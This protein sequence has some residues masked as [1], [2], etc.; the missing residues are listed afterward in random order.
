MYLIVGVDP[1]KTIGIACLDL[2]GRLVF[3]CHHPNE[4]LEH[5]VNSI[6]G[7]GTPIIVA[8][9]KSNPSEL[10]RKLNA[11]FGARLFS[12]KREFSSELKRRL[13]RTVALANQHECDAYSAA[14]AAYNHYSNKFHQI[15]HMSGKGEA[16]L[17]DIK[18][19]VVSKS[20]VYEASSGVRSNRR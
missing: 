6:K 17:E 4:S 14:I 10:V 12:P 20:S 11:T 15:E 16:E 2:R 3:S 7:T 9:D 19:Q 13:G 8:G 1:G 18:R 5:V